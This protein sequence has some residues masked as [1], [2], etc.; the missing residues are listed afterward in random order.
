M[1]SAINRKVKR[2]VVRYQKARP[3]VRISDTT[4]RDGMQTPGIH[5][6]PAQKIIIAQAL[7]DAGVQGIQP[8]ASGVRHVPDVAQWRAAR[9]GAG[10]G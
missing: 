5:L 1:F 7:A 3:L 4:L 2:M 6:D 9:S 8:R 10:A